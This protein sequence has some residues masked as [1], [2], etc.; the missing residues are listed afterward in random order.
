MGTIPAP[1]FAQMCRDGTAFD[2][3]AVLDFFRRNPHFA[4]FD[5]VLK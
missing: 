5:K 2:T 4:T 3:K 1:I